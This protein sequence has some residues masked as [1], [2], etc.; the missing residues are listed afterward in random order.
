M[1]LNPQTA[2]KV[3]DLVSR[4]QERGR[5]PAVAAAVV[6]DGALVH[7]SASG[8]DPSTGAVPTADTQFRIGSITKTLTA[9]MIMQLRDE[10]RLGLE[11]LLY[12][13]LPGT[14][15]GSAI[16]L[17]QMLGHISGLQREPDGPWWE[18][19][20]GSSSRAPAGWPPP[21]PCRAARRA[22]RVY[23]PCAARPSR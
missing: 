15:V 22:H 13:H 10:G 7:F 2:R 9:V 12:R 21:R 19:V 14:P 4:A 20:A 17:R 5:A 23:R 18:R 3:D 16:T 8:S 1:T 6:R 11:D